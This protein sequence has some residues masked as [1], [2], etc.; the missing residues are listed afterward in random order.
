MLPPSGMVGALPDRC[1]VGPELRPE[2][3]TRR[4]TSPRG[5]IRMKLVYLLL[6]RSLEEKCPQQ[7]KDYHPVPR[8][9]GRGRV[10]Q[11]LYESPWRPCEAL[12][13]D[14][15]GLAAMGNGEED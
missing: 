5:E 14:F 8:Q 10:V 2:E 4:T 9:S 15:V 13:D 3:Q 1:P 11:G 7:C 6:S 12:E